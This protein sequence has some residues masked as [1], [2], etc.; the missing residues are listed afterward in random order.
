MGV[1]VKVNVW[2]DYA[3]FSRPEMKVERCSYDVMTPSAARGIL[4]AVYWH[5]GLMW[6]IDKIYV[7]KPIQFTNIRRNEIKSKISA[8]NVLQVMNG[9]DKELYVS[10]K[11]DIVQRASL[12]LRD[13]EYVIE[14]H[15]NMTEK[16]NATDNPGKFQDIFKRRLQSGKCYHTPYFGTRECPV[17]FEPCEENTI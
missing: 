6:I 10:A 9:A 8:N 14:A 7:C 5:P 17:Y 13:V 11:D 15:F 16:A 1:G 3:L 4:E 12:M 2:G